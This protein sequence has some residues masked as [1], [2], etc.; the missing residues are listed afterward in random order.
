M[1]AW[2]WLNAVRQHQQRLFAHWHLL[3]PA[4]GRPLPG[5]RRDT[6]TPRSVGRGVRF[7]S[8]TRQTPFIAVHVHALIEREPRSATRPQPPSLFRRPGLQGD[9]RNPG[10]RDL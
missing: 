8:A 5:E 7:P 4:T 3:S 10:D 9:D 1:P 2:A 6:F